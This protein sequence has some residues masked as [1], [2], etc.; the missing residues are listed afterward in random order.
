[1]DQVSDHPY[2]ELSFDKSG[3]LT[4]PDPDGLIAEV[5]QSGIADLFAMSH[6]W[7]NSTETARG[8]YEAMFPLV[9]KAA[10]QAPGIGPI[11]F[12]GIFWPSLWFPDPPQA[13]PAVAEAV[14]QGRPGA[15]SAA[16][17]GQQIAD[18]LAA[19]FDDPRQQANLEQM[20]RLID[21][22]T[23]G[24]GEEAP[25]SQQARLTRFHAPAPAPGSPGQGRRSSACCLAARTWPRLRARR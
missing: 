4:A 6:G 23:D 12:A 1:M 5:T 3:R 11:G 17:S 9:A 15:A 2:W 24:V 14:Q 16:L 10:A 19:S 13:A 22:G 18:A 20:G 8:L 25:E 21:E 7:G